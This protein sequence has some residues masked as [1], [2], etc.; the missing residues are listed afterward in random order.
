MR[1][2]VNFKSSPPGNYR[3]VDPDTGHT[4]EAID[5]W[6]WLEKAKEHRVA[7]NLPIPDDFFAQMQE[8]LCR[9][10]P[11]ELC[12]YS[13]TDPQYVNT[14]IS[15]ADVIG[16]S[17]IYLEWRKQGKPFV[18][19]EEAERR[20]KICS[21]CY[22]NVRVQGCGG[23]CREIIRITTETNGE[24]KTSQDSK[25]LNCGVCKCTG[26]QVHFPLALLELNDTPQRQEQYPK[27][28][29]W[30]QKTSPNY[31]PE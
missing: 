28:F 9:T 8:Q 19:Q 30:K 25:L 21:G 7:N 16:A 11:P 15:W 26:S 4:T 5:H 27:E 2:L 22:L 31:R 10:L 20:A 14:N 6:T 13:T 29:C 23:L 3:Y 1:T 17:R 12:T 24:R 18:S